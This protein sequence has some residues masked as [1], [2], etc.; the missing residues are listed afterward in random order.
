EL[1][2]AVELAHDR[3]LGALELRPVESVVAVHPTCSARKLGI[4]GKL[5]AV[6]RASARRAVVPI[7]LECCAT[8]GDRGMLYPELSAAA[9]AP[10]AAELAAAGCTRGLASNLTCEIG[11]A[12]VTGIAFG[13]FLD[14]LDEASRP[15]A[16][17][18]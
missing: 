3:L 2:D 6:V 5:E 13:S 7:A 8:A 9:L 15:D 18:P 17:R 10:E 11:L 16:P 1:L 4:A 14:L 12:E